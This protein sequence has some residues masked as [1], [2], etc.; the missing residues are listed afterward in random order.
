MG[1]RINTSDGD[2]IEVALVVPRN[3]RYDDIDRNDFIQRFDTGAAFDEEIEEALD[4]GWV[5]KIRKVGE[6]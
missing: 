5:R 6:W 4:K 2:I 3:Y 1:I